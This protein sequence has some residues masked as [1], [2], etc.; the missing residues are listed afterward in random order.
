MYREV[1][2]DIEAAS[3]NPAYS[4]KIKLYHHLKG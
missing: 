3:K 4:G 2:E 1:K